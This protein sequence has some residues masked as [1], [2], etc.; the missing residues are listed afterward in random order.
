M[1]RAKTG[2]GA[3]PHRVTIQ[4]PSIT[5]GSDGG[6]IT[7]TG[8]EVDVRWARVEP[9]MGTERLRLNQMSVEASHRVI[10]RQKM[11]GVDETM[12]VSFDS[13]TFNIRSVIQDYRFGR[14][15]MLYCEEHKAGA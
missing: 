8:A 2:A 3:F 1:S 11:T 12:T 7:G 15:T 4:Q 14:S 6:L 5:V 10:L 13:R 9:L